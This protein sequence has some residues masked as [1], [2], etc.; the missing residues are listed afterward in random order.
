MNNSLPARH[1][2]TKQLKYQYYLAVS[3]LA[4]K[5]WRKIKFFLQ[6]KLPVV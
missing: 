2:E 5:I 4:Q 6:E 3:V 1:K